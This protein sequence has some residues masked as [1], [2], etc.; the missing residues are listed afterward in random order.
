MKKILSGMGAAVA[1]MLTTDYARAEI[2]GGDVSLTDLIF[3][4][5]LSHTPRQASPI[6]P[7]RRFRSKDEANQLK[8]VA[9]LRREQRAV[10][11][12]SQYVSTFR[13]VMRDIES[14]WITPLLNN[15]DFSDLENHTKFNAAHVGLPLL[16]A[17]QLRAYKVV[18]K[19]F[20]RVQQFSITKPVD[21]IGIVTG[22][23]FTIEPDAKVAIKLGGYNA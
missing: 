14:G 6:S 23:P 13:G 21:L 3:Y 11:R 20:N 19:F 22:A 4:K 10:K 16:S 7:S 18:T 1:A 17:W 9:E 12:H 2:R 8:N 5:M 15:G